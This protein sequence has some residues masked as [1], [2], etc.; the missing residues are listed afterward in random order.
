MRA[1]VGDR[2]HVHGRTVGNADRVGEIVEVRGEDGRPPY[3][4]RFEDGN[5]R[6][7]FPGPDSTVEEPTES[8]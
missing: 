8:K 1:K 7:M 6:L 2:L 4:V 5:E 3:R